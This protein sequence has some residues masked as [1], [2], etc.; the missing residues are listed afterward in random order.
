MGWLTSPIVFISNVINLFF[1]QAFT[2]S[3]YME[4]AKLMTNVSIF[5]Q[6]INLRSIHE[7]FQQSARILMPCTWWVVSSPSPYHS[8][9]HQ[10]SSLSHRVVVAHS[11]QS[12]LVI[13]WLKVAATLEVEAAHATT[14]SLARWAPSVLSLFCHRRCIAPP[15]LA[16]PP[17]A[18]PR[19]TVH[20]L[21]SLLC[22]RLQQQL[23]PL[24]L[25]PALATMCLFLMLCLRILHRH[26]HSLGSRVIFPCFYVLLLGSQ[27]MVV[28][29]W[30]TVGGTF[31]L[32]VADSGCDQRCIQV[33]SDRTSA[34]LWKEGGG[35]CCTDSL[36]NKFKCVL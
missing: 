11:M 32:A 22:H 14:Q 12:A 25:P 8:Q 36:V 6:W 18:N 9:E 21:G 30:L 33:R 19:L 7:Q 23:W 13:F 3:G 24:H 16:S 31:A 20:S 1:E 17:L 28:L 4:T 5:L 34:V 29:W 35:G 27:L 10:I 15:P 2:Q 26:C